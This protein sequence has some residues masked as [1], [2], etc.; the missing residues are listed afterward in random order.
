LEGVHRLPLFPFD[1]RHFDFVA[2]LPQSDILISC[3]RLSLHSPL[4]WISLLG[5]LISSGQNAPKPG[6]RL[7]VFQGEILTLCGVYEPPKLLTYQ[8]FLI[9]IYIEN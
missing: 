1:D 6:L 4:P 8:Y 2:P 5:A 3:R 7:P 9:K